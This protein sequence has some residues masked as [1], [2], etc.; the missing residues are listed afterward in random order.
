M[1]GIDYHPIF[2]EQVYN[3]VF[4]TNRKYVIN[5]TLSP[6][7]NRDVWKRAIEA[8]TDKIKVQGERT[9]KYGNC[10]EPVK[11]TYP[12]K[13]KPVKR[14]VIRLSSQDLLAKRRDSLSPSVKKLSTSV[15]DEHL[16][17]ILVREKGENSSLL[18]TPTE[19]LCYLVNKY[20]LKPSEE[21]LE[22]INK[23][24]YDLEGFSP[25]EIQR[26][27]IKKILTERVEDFFWSLAKQ[28]GAEGELNLSDE[29]GF[30]NEV[31]KELIEWI[32]IHH[33]DT[34]PVLKQLY[35]D[36]MLFA[37]K[38]KPKRG[39][40]TLSFENDRL[41][42]KFSEAMRNKERPPLFE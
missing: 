27:D 35:K 28:H 1:P 33:N 34:G 29:T 42:L 2:D 11:I 32:A 19:A 40:G 14:P 21:E 25:E 12:F 9:T 8:L 13:N 17:V 18:F 4:G 6:P 3:N 22:E 10:R 31:S 36:L 20:M 37:A 24:A 16:D 41:I 5:R 23:A 30:T 15:L 26:A 39:W 7:D 38:V